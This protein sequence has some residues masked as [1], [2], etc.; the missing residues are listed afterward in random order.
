MER[1]LF[2]PGGTQDAFPLRLRL[3]CLRESARRFRWHSGA[4]G[5]PWLWLE[6]CAWRIRQP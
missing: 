5:D 2:P 4:R 1:Q 6:A 3:P